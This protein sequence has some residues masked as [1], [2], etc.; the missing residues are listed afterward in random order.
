MG[1]PCG[2]AGKESTCNAGDLGSIPGLGRAPGEGKGYPLQYSGLEN[3]M[4]CIVHGVAMSWTRLSDFHFTSLVHIVWWYYRERGK[5]YSVPY[6]SSQSS[7]EDIVTEPNLDLL[8][9]VQ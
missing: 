8:A 1:F 9:C 4:D 3:S 5:T 6:E 2:S 7:R